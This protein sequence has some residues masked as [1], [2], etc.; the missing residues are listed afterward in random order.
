MVE[1]SL[2]AIQCSAH[3]IVPIGVAVPD[4]HCSTGQRPVKPLPLKVG[5]VIEGEWREVIGS[6]SL[7][8]INKNSGGLILIIR[9]RLFRKVC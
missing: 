3:V 8:E 5:V 2:T 4:A 6:F 1:S 7:I 9:G